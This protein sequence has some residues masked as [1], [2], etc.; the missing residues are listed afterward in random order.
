[1]TQDS[2]TR[3]EFLRVA[4]GAAALAATGPACGSGSGRPEPRRAQDATPKGGRTLRIVQWTHF[5]PAY[6][7]WFDSFAER[8]GREHDTDVFVDHIG[9]ADI[10]VRAAAEVAAGRGHDLFGFLVTP[11]AAFVDD[12]LDVNDVVEDI[13]DRTGP[14]LPFLER[15]VR[16]P[17]T[18]RYLAVPDF[19][20]P[21]PVHY[22]PD[23]WDAIRP[24]L[25][26][27]SWEAILGAAPE[28]KAAGTP[29]G[30]GFSSYVDSSLS[31][32]SLLFAFGASLQ[33][34]EGVLTLDSREAVEAVKLGVRLFH[35]GLSQ[36]TLTWDDS[37]D[38]RFLAS[39]NGSLTIDAISAIRA[40]EKQ[41]PP[42][43]AKIALAPLPTGPAG[44]IGA[45]GPIQSYAIW[46]FARNPTAAR[47]FLVDL[48]VG[49]REALLNSEFY[50]LPAFPGAV[51]DL[52]T[53]LAADTVADPRD[54]YSVLASATEWST[55]I[56][57]PGYD[58]PAVAEVF[59]EFVVPRMF[60]AAARG[61]LSAEDAVKTA[62]AQAAAI[63]DKWRERGKI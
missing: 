61:E 13:H 24:G 21:N 20:G 41:D 45:V 52:P 3:R 10:A 40:V 43:A 9:N 7:Q 8:W 23:L 26:P 54:K 31:V 28:L 4:A 46:K 36:D 25:R 59:S 14:M 58:N 49:Y 22:R 63:F 32:L 16:D 15:S 48:V 6:D 12:V 2:F 56:G 5:V 33:N 62:S 19:W 60:A 11:V 37:A 35:S 38:N 55:N 17:K 42:L 1:M 51:P 29:V 27:D 50:N 39:G 30:I 57:H 47:Q 18:G 53:I 34:R 44:R